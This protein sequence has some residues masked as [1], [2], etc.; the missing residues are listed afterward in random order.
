MEKLWKYVKNNEK[1]S[2][3]LIKKLG[4]SPIVAN[5][6]T[7][8]GI[9]DPREAEKFLKKAHQLRPEDAAIASHYNQVQ[10]KLK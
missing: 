5:L 7:N 9:V 4:I 8:R 3:R 2:K 1:S 10:K 6:L